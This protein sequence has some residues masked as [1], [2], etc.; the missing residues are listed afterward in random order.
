ME[1]MIRNK[2]FWHGL[3]DKL[4]RA[5]G[6]RL[7]WRGSADLWGA[8]RVPF[9]GLVNYPNGSMSFSGF[10]VDGSTGCAEL[11]D[12]P[13]TLSGSAN[14]AANCPAYGTRTFGSANTTTT[15]VKLVQ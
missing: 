4:P 7:D 1:K 2:A 14:L 3:L 6:F 15:A 9:I 10:S 13:I 8:R 12:R 5:A 11:I